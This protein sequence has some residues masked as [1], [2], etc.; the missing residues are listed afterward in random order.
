MVGRFGG[1]GVGLREACGSYRVQQQCIA[2][3]TPHSS[4]SAEAGLGFCY[5]S[6]T[7]VD[8]GSAMRTDACVERQRG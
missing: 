4:Q 5:A 7:S 8:V 2:F 6:R 3:L 1:H